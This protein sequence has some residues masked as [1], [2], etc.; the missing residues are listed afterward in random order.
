MKAPKSVVGILLIIVFFT[1]S[2]FIATS[3]V[4]ASQPT[5]SS[6][7]I[8]S[9]KFFSIKPVAF[10][11][12]IL[13]NQEPVQ[14]FEFNFDLDDISQILKRNPISET[15]GADV[16]DMDFGLTYV[17]NPDGSFTLTINVSGSA[18]NEESG[19]QLGAEGSITLNFDNEYRLTSVGGEA[20]VKY[21]F[22][23]DTYFITF[24][25]GPVPVWVQVNVSASVGLKA[26]GD[27]SFQNLTPRRADLSI[28]L[29]LNVELE[30]LLYSLVGGS[31]AVE[32]YLD[33]RYYGD[34]GVWVV[35]AGTSVSLKG[36]VGVSTPFYSKEHVFWASNWDLSTPIYAIERDAGTAGDAGEIFSQARELS[37]NSTC[38]GYLGRE[39]PTTVDTED[40]YQVEFS[41]GSI[42]KVNLQSGSEHSG[43][44]DFDLYLYNA[45]GNELASSETS[46]SHET[47]SYAVGS[48]GIYYIKVKL[49]SGG[50]SWGLYTLDLATELQDDAGSG[51]D[52]GNTSGTSL[53]LTPFFFQYPCEGDE[54]PYVLEFFSWDNCYLGGGDERDFYKVYAST[55]HTLKAMVTPPEGANFDLYFLGPEL[56][57]LASSTNP[58]DTQESL[59]YP[60]SSPGWY[61]LEVRRTGGSGNYSLE[62]IRE[63]HDILRGDAPGSAENAREITPGS[64]TNC[65]LD[66]VDRD[67]YYSFTANLK[68]RVNIFL[69]STW[70]TGCFFTV[71]DGEGGA[72]AS[73]DSSVRFTVVHP[74]THFIRVW[75]QSGTPSYGFTLEVQSQDDAGSS[76][77]AGDTMGDVLEISPGTYSG[78][79][80]AWDNVDFYRENVSE[81]QTFWVSVQPSQGENLEVDL[82]ILEST[83]EEFSG[84]LVTD[85]S[86]GNARYFCG[87]ASSSTQYYLKI[88][89]VDGEGYYSLTVAKRYENDAGSERD[90]G[91]TQ[92]AAV[93]LS[94][95]ENYFGHLSSYDTEDLYKVYL[96][97]NDQLTVKVSSEGG[98]LDPDLYLYN[99]TAVFRNPAEIAAG[100]ST[101]SG[102][103]QDSVT[104]LAYYPGWYYIRVKR[105]SGSGDYRLELSTLQ[106]AWP[107]IRHD[108]HSTGRS[109]YSGSQ[110]GT[111]QWKFKVHESSSWWWP[112]V[113]SPVIGLDDT[114]YVKVTENILYALNPD[115]TLK[116]SKIFDTAGSSIATSPTVGPDG[117]VYVGVRYSIYALD[118]QT[119]SIKW[120]KTTLTCPHGSPIVGSDGTIYST[121]PRALWALDPDLWYRVKWYCWIGETGTAYS[122]QTPTISSIT[123][124]LYY[125]I[126]DDL[127]MVD[128]TLYSGLENY[129]IIDADNIPKINLGS[130]I[131]TTPAV[132]A[133]GRIY[134]STKDNVVALSSSGEILWVFSD[135]GYHYYSSPA[136]GQDNT[137]YFTSDGGKLY[138][139]NP[140]GTLK[141]SFSHHVRHYNVVF[142]PVPP[143]VLD[144]DNNIYFC[145]G[146]ALYAVDSSGN[147]KWTFEAGGEIFAPPAI[148]RDGTIYFTSNDGYLYAVR[149][150]STP[151]TSSV[152][153]PSDGQ[154]LSEISA[155]S[156]TATDDLSGIHSVRVRIKRSWDGKYWCQ[157]GGWTSDGSTA[158]YLMQYAGDN[159][160]VFN[161]DSSNFISGEIYLIELKA[162]DR[163]GNEEE[164]RGVSFTFDTG[165]PFCSLNVNHDATYTRSQEVTLYLA[166]SDSTSPVVAARYSNDGTNWTEWEPVA[167]TKSWTLPTGAG[168]KTVY[169]QV[170]DAAGNLSP[171][172]SDSIIL[173]TAGLDALSLISPATDNVTDWIPEF[174]WTSGALLPGEAYLVEIEGV[175][176]PSYH[177][178]T[179]TRENT[180]TLPSV[181][182]LELPTNKVTGVQESQVYRWRVS[183][184]SPFVGAIQL[185]QW[186]SFTL[187]PPSNNAPQ[188]QL[189]EFGINPLGDGLLELNAS[190]TNYGAPLMSG[191]GGVY[192]IPVSFSYT[193]P[194]T[195]TSVFISQQ[196]VVGVGSLGTGETVQGSVTWS[197]PEN[198]NYQVFCQTSKGGGLAEG[199]SENEA[200]VRVMLK[201]DLCLFSED[202]TYDESLNAIWARVH[203]WGSA[204]VATFTVAFY[205]DGSRTDT[206]VASL[207]AGDTVSAT[208][209]WSLSSGDHTIRVVVD[210]DGAISET[211]EANNEATITV[212][213]APPPSE[214]TAGGTPS[215]PSGGEE[216]LPAGGAAGPGR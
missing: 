87:K 171:V 55:G 216:R 197:P 195:G 31:G 163:D 67:D 58:G 64:Y 2:V 145:S 18:E 57:C 168:E 115:G 147:F 212:S 49:A 68:D 33:A 76:G 77:D 196:F 199:V 9:E 19:S 89:R 205:V 81:N 135:P 40:L 54:G 165:A 144:G 183:V 191:L 174:C 164:P 11:P 70:D 39:S 176:D 137:I 105:S 198:E 158:W 208:V 120:S 73:S 192:M 8:P 75:R 131:Q 203:N 207:A 143:P 86:L 46:G 72:I 139:V 134:V 152:I 161:L 103:A 107:I 3:G 71:L 41:A 184:L 133:D 202:V 128:L 121:Y 48:S 118:P 172:A 93:T 111:L 200:E 37:P 142:Y 27:V 42:I 102:V 214:E 78:W 173:I 56:S 32:P 21:T 24:S 122:T 5:P 45:Y 35:F 185:S 4:L 160:Y 132:G 7:E 10:P 15:K 98:N 61:Y 179:M 104:Y 36:K 178:R 99:S 12:A 13:L 167:S 213:I 29:Y 146:N 117:T 186:Q 209:A 109:P 14:N 60:V 110:R 63:Q 16:P 1:P 74:G 201:P 140:N 90:A 34:W 114:I 101:N 127:W 182:Q 69:S 123:G 53:N 159:S 119:G 92:A 215:Q 28:K 148:G 187:V 88:S 170:M 166:C 153:S 83:G 189:D 84:E 100:S 26:Q 106:A 204:D 194:E 125:G 91:W 129:S 62:V 124:H 113:S 43:D 94:S 177:F 79:V 136:I 156:A 190:F 151:P 51:G 95:G 65:Y 154:Y 66:E 59:E 157:Q 108:V 25:V 138:A 149:H 126:G 30:A 6:T 141:W 193:S 50:R 175:S 22:F 82:S 38:A 210:P 112:S 85:A 188:I 206:Q 155:I 80:D 17:E 97:M 20:D 169:Y 44:V 211:D 52:A 180:F 162:I 96:G 116:W 181:H 150:D 23:Y 130:P 47:I